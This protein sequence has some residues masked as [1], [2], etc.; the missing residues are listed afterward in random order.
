MSGSSND[1]D[2]GND[3][4]EEE[5]QYRKRTQHQIQT[6]LVEI[7]RKIMEGDND[8]EIMQSL[9]LRR[10]TFYYYKD[11]LYKQ[12]LT[13]QT[14]KKTDEMV[15]FETQILKERFSKIYKHLDKRLTMI[16]QDPKVTDNIAEIA[17]VAS[18]VARKILHIEMEGLK[19]LSG[20]NENK[21]LRFLNRTYCDNYNNNINNDNNKL[22]PALNYYFNNQ[23]QE[24]V[25]VLLRLKPRKYRY[26][27][28]LITYGLVLSRSNIP[29]NY[30]IEFSFSCY[31]CL[32]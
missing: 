17:V 32:T 1:D 19:A 16:N 24:E 10:R 29:I 28:Y 27:A 22:L 8:Q 11:K 6:M 5:Q 4:I 18:E 21:Y 3:N 31:H 26:K 2:Y 13:I 12:S 15:A 9:S 23:S 30:L 20:I 25:D 14:S 7:E